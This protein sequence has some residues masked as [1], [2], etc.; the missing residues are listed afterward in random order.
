MDLFVKLNISLS[1][2]MGDFLSKSQA[3]RIVSLLNQLCYNAIRKMTDI[4]RKG[5]LRVDED[6]IYRNLVNFDNSI[7]S[8]IFR[9]KDVF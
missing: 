7:H 6:T 3:K 4:N 1:P 2:F 8:V 5:K 9:L